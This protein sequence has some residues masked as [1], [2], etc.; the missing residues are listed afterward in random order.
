MMQSIFQK[1]FWLVLSVRKPYNTTRAPL[2]FRGEDK[3]TMAMKLV[4]LAGGQQSTISNE[5]EGV[6]KPMVDIGGKPVLWHIMKY[7]SAHGVKEF[8][9][10][11]GYKVGM[12]KEYFMNYYIYQSDITV[13]L[14]EN[15]IEIHKKRTEDW[16]VTVVDTGIYASTAQRVSRVQEYI[17]KE[18]FLVTYGD[19]LEDIDVNAF[20]RQHRNS[21]R[22]CTLAVARPSGRNVILPISEKGNLM[23]DSVARGTDAW[24]SAGIYAFS[25]KVF[26]YFQGS[27]EL[28]Y[29]VKGILADQKQVSIYKHPGFWQPVETRRDL[30][31]ME[32]MWN[33]EMAPW[34]K[35][36]D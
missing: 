34:K 21:N 2:F 14:Q 25:P 5:R 26:N 30:V 4:I 16:Q 36:Q 17:G 10:C 1:G 22:I 6:P 3:E 12:L 35:W 29:F 27:Y 7:F 8:I 11:G 9:I 33:A 15:T 13:D 18:D 31:M 32:N 28:D 19:C 20:W 24:T 23:K